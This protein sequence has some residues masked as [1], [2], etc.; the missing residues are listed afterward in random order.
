MK[1]YFAQALDLNSDLLTYI[2]AKKICSLVLCFRF[3]NCLQEK[4]RA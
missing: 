2:H 4:S 1:F 3:S